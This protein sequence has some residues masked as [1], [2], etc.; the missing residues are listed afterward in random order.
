MKTFVT[1]SLLT[2]SMAS[3]APA[4]PR[5]SPFEHDRTAIVTILSDD[6]VRN[7]FGSP[8]DP[9]VSG[10]TAIHPKDRKLEPNV[11]VVKNETCELEV[12]FNYVCDGAFCSFEAAVLKPCDTK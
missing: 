6:T 12:K 3:S 2:F 10:I 7:S 5:P 4:N 8:T 11:W 1:L 9:T